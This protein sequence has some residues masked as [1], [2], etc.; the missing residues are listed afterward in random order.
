MNKDNIVTNDVPPNPP[1]PPPPRIISEDSTPIKWCKKACSCK[2]NSQY[3]MK[4]ADVKYIYFEVYRN[5]FMDNNKPTLQQ[6]NVLTFCPHTNSLGI[7]GYR[8]R[9]ERTVKLGQSVVIVDQYW[10]DLSKYTHSY[11]EDSQFQWFGFQS[12][13]CDW[14][15]AAIDHIKS[16]LQVGTMDEDTHSFL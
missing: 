5:T 2:C 11:S 4:M 8:N 1:P 7:W 14:F 13:K 6:V 15:Q 3:I 12:D 16:S 9:T 10:V